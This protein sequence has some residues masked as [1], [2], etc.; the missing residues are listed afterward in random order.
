MYKA[1]AALNLM[2]ALV[3]SLWEAPHSI[4][5]CFFI[6]LGF[7]GGARA[8]A[9]PPHLS[10]WG[11]MPNADGAPLISS[12]RRGSGVDVDGNDLPLNVL[13]GGRSP[14][15][16]NDAPLKGADTSVSR[17]PQERSEMMRLCCAPPAGER[18][19]APTDVG[20]IG[21]ERRRIGDTKLA[22]QVVD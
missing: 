2:P 15:R 22:V 5:I 8:G 17:N 10:R 4:S 12:R 1:R 11:G 20:G 18:R 14:R 9:G 13:G 3:H 21:S 6:S 19:A 16:L 7:D